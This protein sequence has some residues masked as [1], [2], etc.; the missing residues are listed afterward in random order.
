M[1][2][3]ALAAV[4][5]KDT[6]DSAADACVAAG[7]A[8]AA[9]AAITG[10]TDWQD[11][12]PP[13]RRIGLVHALLN[14]TATSL[15]TASLVQRRRD[16]RAGGRGLGLLGFLVASMAARLGGNLVYEHRIGV[17]HAVE[18]PLPEQFQPTIAESELEENKPKRVEVNGTPIV[19]VR[20]GSEI[21][22]LAE[23]C[24]HLGGPLAE[25]KVENGAIQ[26][27]WHGSRFSLKDGRVV[28][29]P[30]VHSQPCLEARVRNGKIEVRKKIS[31]PD[32]FTSLR[33][34]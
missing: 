20:S 10:L 12:D 26:C 22:A 6:M 27:P 29:G 30:A 33:A 18:K 28:N 19:L 17:D 13:A 2:F 31:A 32:S 8:G 5:G 21:Y 7:L 3:D 15:M 9:G 11:V 24:S 34:A 4:S 16:S 25:G 1:A 14:I 23:T